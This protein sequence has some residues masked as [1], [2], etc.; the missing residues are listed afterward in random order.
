MKKIITL[1]LCA[2]YSSLAFSGNEK[3]QADAAGSHCGISTE[4]SVAN[5]VHYMGQLKTL[6]NNPYEH[7]LLLST[8]AKNIGSEC[9]VVVDF[10]LKLNEYAQNQNSLSNRSNEIYLCSENTSLLGSADG[11]G[12]YLHQFIQTKID[13]CIKGKHDH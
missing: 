12:N 10:K 2:L 1:L 3:N 7:F 5:A 9:T 6:Q 4:T 11:L 8:V 13:A